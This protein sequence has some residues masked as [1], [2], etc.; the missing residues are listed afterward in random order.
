LNVAWFIPLDSGVVITLCSTSDRDYEECSRWLAAIAANGATL[1]I[2]DVVD[3]E[4]RRGQLLAPAPAQLA[5]LN[6]LRKRFSKLTEVTPAAWA[7]AAEFWAH[8]RKI[9][10]PTAGPK[11]LDADAVL[12]AV[13]ATIA[14]RG[15]RVT[16]ATTNVKHLN[17]FPGVDAR[18]WRDIT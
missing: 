2:P 6:L 7:K 15:A 3:Y 13:A 12:A 11:S 14:R 17:R 18:E 1:V 9:G 10:E 8:V 5:R 4:V 16:I